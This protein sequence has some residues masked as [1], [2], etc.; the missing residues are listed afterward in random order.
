[1]RGTRLWAMLA[2]NPTLTA[3]FQ[4]VGV[5]L[6]VMAIAVWAIALTTIQ[7]VHAEIQSLRHQVL[8]PPEQNT[9]PP[10]EEA[11]LQE[12]ATTAQ[13]VR[14]APNP[15]AYAISSLSQ[16]A[17]Q[18]GLTVISVESSEVID[19]P[20]VEGGWK[21]RLLRFQLQGSSI[22][23]MAW[24]TQ[25]ERVRLVTKVRGVQITTTGTQKGRLS[26]V[27]EMEV[28]LPDPNATV[29]GEPT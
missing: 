3:R 19:A 15:Q 9:I 29:G 28:L 14:D 7:R 4:K 22:Q 12:I 8:N 17:Q 11:F 5:A 20:P 24:L 27:V 10:E 2:L 26:A 21:P 13:Q 18:Q 1:M 25:L 23:V 6:A 16:S